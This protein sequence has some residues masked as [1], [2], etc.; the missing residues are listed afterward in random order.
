MGLFDDLFKKPKPSDILP[1]DVRALRDIGRITGVLPSPGGK[2]PTTAELRAPEVDVDVL[3]EDNPTAI[4][5]ALL[6]TQTTAFYQDLQSRGSIGENDVQ[7]LLS[8]GNLA[9]GRASSAEQAA[10]AEQALTQ[11]FL[12]GIVEG[13]YDDP[14][15][16]TAAIGPFAERL[17]MIQQMGGAAAGEP[18]MTQEDEILLMYEQ[19][20]REQ[21][22]FQE[23]EFYREGLMDIVGSAPSKSR[24]NVMAA[25]LEDPN[26]RAMFLP[27]AGYTFGGGGIG[28]IGG[29][30]GA[31]APSGTPYA[32][33]FL[34][35]FRG[36]RG[37]GGE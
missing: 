24:F 5:D 6:K 19:Q 27:P 7:M 8:L 15:E 12:A 26:L 35:E 23:M 2:V 22:Q 21:A 4:V 25:F 18:A 33:V 9:T 37:R 1:A 13:R 16:F 14:D 29:E 10:F 3:S 28:S 17:G 31:A 20:Q 30:T 11:D 34:E 32:D 36:G